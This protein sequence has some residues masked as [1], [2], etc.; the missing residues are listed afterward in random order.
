MSLHF[1]GRHPKNLKNRIRILLF[2]C[3]SQATKD[4]G[5]KSTEPSSKQVS[6]TGYKR[7]EGKNAWDDVKVLELLVTVGVNVVSDKNCVAVNVRV[8]DLRGY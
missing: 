2:V 8:L 3:F 6:E 5:K 7:L 4:I 1:D